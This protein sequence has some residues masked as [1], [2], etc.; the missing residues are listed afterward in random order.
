MPLGLFTHTTYEPEFLAFKPRAKLLLVT[1][2]VTESRRGASEFG[3][4]RVERL[5]AN[6]KTDS[7]SQICETVLQQA[8]AFGNHPW[9][10]INDRLHHRRRRRSDDLTAVALVRD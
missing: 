3:A 10:R 8:H 6:V 2:G 9:S 5:L 7:A 1:K 4:E